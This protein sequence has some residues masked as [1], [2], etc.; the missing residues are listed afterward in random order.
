GWLQMETLPGIGANAFRA[1]TDAV[2]LVDEELHDIGIGSRRVLPGLVEILIGHGIA[3]LRPVGPHQEP[4]APRHLAVPRLPIAQ[5][6]DSEE[7]IGV[8]GRL[9]RAV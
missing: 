6:I 5:E 3:A 8:C 2:A 7:E 1:E 4:A 9:L